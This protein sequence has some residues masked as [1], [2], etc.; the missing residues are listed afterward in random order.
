MS[1]HDDED[2]NPS[3]EDQE[4]FGGATR[5]CPECRTEVYDDAEI[6]HECGHAFEVRREPS[7]WVTPVVIAVIVAIVLGWTGLRVFM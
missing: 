3:L 4:R 7:K 6:C 5:V 1:R 2:E